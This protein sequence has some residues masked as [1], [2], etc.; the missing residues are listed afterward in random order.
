ML[1]TMQGTKAC[2]FRGGPM[3]G[4]SGDYVDRGQTEAF[5]GDGAEAGCYVYRLDPATADRREAVWVYDDKA[6]TALLR[7]A[8]LLQQGETGVI[9]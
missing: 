2:R 4:W 3:T 1:G 8:G 7:A 9:T 5:F 6:S